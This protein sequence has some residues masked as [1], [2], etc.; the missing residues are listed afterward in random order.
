MSE[1]LKIVVGYDGSDCVMAA[2]DDLRRAG[3]PEV[4]QA[5]VVSVVE[6]SLSLSNLRSEAMG[7][8]RISA[9]N[10]PHEKAPLILEEATELA[11]KAVERLQQLFPLW[12]ISAASD[13]GSPASCILARAGI[14][15]ADLI[16]VGSH[17]RS[18]LGHF[19]LGSVSH[20]VVAEA[21]CSVRIAQGRVAEPTSPLRLLIGIDG[22]EGAEAALQAVVERGWPE[23]TK[24]RVVTAFDLIVPPIA[25]YLM[26]PAAKWSNEDNEAEQAHAKHLAETAAGT[27]R[28]AGLDA[29]A[30]IKVG[31]PKHALLKEA[32]EWQ[33]DCIFVGARGLNRLDR[34]LL[35]SVSMICL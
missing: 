2:L 18:P 31:N 30:R 24:A 33:A 21:H 17:G 11:Y 19:L 15:K 35:G 16:V 26:P 13:W 34:F 10:F 5:V 22:S 27:L 6:K 1:R 9:K 23:G 3:L 4:A 14:L 28:G 32:E 29:S 25:S 8:Q 7:E 20:T 12:E